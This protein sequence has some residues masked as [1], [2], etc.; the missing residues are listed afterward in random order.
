MKSVSHTQSGKRPVNLL[1]SERNVERARCYTANLSAT[2][3]ALLAEFVAKEAQQRQ[4]QRQRYVEVASAWNRF[5]EMH[6]S[7]AD[8][9][10]TL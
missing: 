6:G 2:V 8:E 7:F 1:L 10:S 5:E 4:D 9:H 3:D